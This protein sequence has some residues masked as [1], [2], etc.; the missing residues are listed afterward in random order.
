MAFNF[1]QIA[2]VK[3]IDLHI[4]SGMRT[5]EEQQALYDQGRTKPGKI[6]T[7]AKP[8]TSFH[9]YGLAIDVIPFVDSKPDWNTKLWPEISDIGKGL[10]FSWGGDWKTFKDLPHFEFPANT[11][12]KVL[13][14]LHNA[15]KLDKEGYVVL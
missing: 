11:S 5:F 13:L 7:K 3:G 15:G 4:T 2:K 9:N 10:G 8:G 6:V 1:L 14:A 12:Y